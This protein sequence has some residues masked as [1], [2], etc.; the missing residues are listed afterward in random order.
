M[1]I[2]TVALLLTGQLFT[3][4]Q[5]FKQDQQIYQTP[6]YGTEQKELL[7]K[8]SY[9]CHRAI[10]TASDY[11]YTFGKKSE[12]TDE[13]LAKNANIIDAIESF[14][15]YNCENNPF[16]QSIE[17]RLMSKYSQEIKNNQDR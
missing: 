3:P 6:T 4:S 2:V 7:K 12:L 11:N 13:Q 15:H 8:Q 1:Q 10:I 14:Q 17:T 9:L 16:I 5:E